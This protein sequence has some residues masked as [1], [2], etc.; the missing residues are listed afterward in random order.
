MRSEHV[1]F[2]ER[3]GE[4][5]MADRMIGRHG[6]MTGAEMQAPWLAFRLD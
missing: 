1:L 4:K 5:M 2:S 3:E 6:G